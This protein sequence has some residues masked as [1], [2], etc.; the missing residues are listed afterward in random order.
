MYVHWTCVFIS[1]YIGCAHVC[2]YVLLCKEYVYVYTC[3]VL[4]HACAGHSTQFLLTGFKNTVFLSVRF[5]VLGRMVVL[6]TPPPWWVQ[7]VLLAEQGSLWA[8]VSLLCSW[9]FLLMG[10]SQ[11]LFELVNKLVCIHF[12]L[13]SLMHFNS[14]C[15]YCQPNYCWWYYCTTTT[16]STTSSTTLHR[17]LLY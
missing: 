12:F 4:G 7:I 16:T 8:L 11:I 14:R 1:K 5:C 9:P 3:Y 6:F 17:L 2:V 15:S 13:S 10:T